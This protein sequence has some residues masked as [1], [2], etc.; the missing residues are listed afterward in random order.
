MLNI[1]PHYAI[2]M[3]ISTNV[4]N[5]F[6]IFFC[7]NSLH[8][9]HISAH[10]CCLFDIHIKKLFY[11]INIKRGIISKEIPFNQ[12]NEHVICVLIFF[13]IMFSEFWK[14]FSIL[15][16]H[17][18]FLSG[19]AIIWIFSRHNKQKL[20]TEYPVNQTIQKST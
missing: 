5:C 17:F 16:D 11:S 12:I 8:F 18:V 10:L 1:S 7:K 4:G 15:I 14:G 2:F 9:I 20:L 3:I 6:T 19:A 13:V